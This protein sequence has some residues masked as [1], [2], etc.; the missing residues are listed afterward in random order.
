MKRNW[1]RPKGWWVTYVGIVYTIYLLFSFY[2]FYRGNQVQHNITTL[3]KFIYKWLNYRKWRGVALWMKFIVKRITSTGKRTGDEK[4]IFEYAAV[5]AAALVAFVAQ[6]SVSQ[7]LFIRK[8]HPYR[9]DDLF[10]SRKI[11]ISTVFFLSF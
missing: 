5:C 10:F 9:S 8:V 6:I 2:R 7:P 11:I 4:E 1:P 3:R